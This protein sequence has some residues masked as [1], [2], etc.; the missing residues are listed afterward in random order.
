MTA[1]AS[2]IAGPSTEVVLESKGCRSDS[3]ES[4]STEELNII[5]LTDHAVYDLFKRSL[6]PELFKK[7]RIPISMHWEEEPH[8]KKLLDIFL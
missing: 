1:T 7:F 5:D 4:D 6:R 8:C 2:A 3:V